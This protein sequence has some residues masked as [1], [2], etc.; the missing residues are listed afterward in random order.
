MYGQS[1]RPTE[2]PTPTRG[3][4]EAASTPILPFITG[5]MMIPKNGW[6][7]TSRVG[8]RVLRN[9]KKTRKPSS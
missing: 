6:M 9:L 5:L 1:R 7:N 2:M 4:F 3:G 8:I